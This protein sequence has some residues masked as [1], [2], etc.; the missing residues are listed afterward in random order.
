MMMMM[1]MI[2]IIIILIISSS[3]NSSN[4]NWTDIEAMGSSRSSRA[5][6]S[7]KGA[8]A[9]TAV[10]GASS[11]A[12]TKALAA[13]HKHQQLQLNRQ[14]FRCFLHGFL[15]ILTSSLPRISKVSFFSSVHI[16]VQPF[17]PNSTLP[18]QIDHKYSSRHFANWMVVEC[19]VKTVKTIPLC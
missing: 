14:R 1:M 8:G 10:A 9:A 11:A 19:R 7:K 15:E 2:I 13:A 5:S 16:H 17:V 6:S 18:L 4:I 12:G 3:S